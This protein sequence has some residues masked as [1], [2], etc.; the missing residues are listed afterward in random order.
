MNILRAV[1]L[2]KHGYCGSISCT[3]I[4]SEDI[5]SSWAKN[6]QA[7]NKEYEESTMG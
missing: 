4:S 3:V 1:D 6:C 2:L 5:W 7:K